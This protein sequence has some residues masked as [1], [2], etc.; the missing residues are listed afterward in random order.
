MVFLYIC[1]VL[2]C[3]CINTFVSLK[4]GRPIGLAFSNASPTTLV[5][6]LSLWFIFLNARI[7]QKWGRIL[8]PLSE[9]TY[10]VFLSHV[11]VLDLINVHVMKYFPVSTAGLLVLRII[12]LTVLVAVIC[13]SIGLIVNKYP[14][15]KKV[16]G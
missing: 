11:L 1:S 4:H 14:K 5:M 7:S 8:K 3:F 12:L 9:S 16:L 13:F 10:F 6:S 2:V 15:L